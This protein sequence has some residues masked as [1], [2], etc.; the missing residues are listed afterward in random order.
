LNFVI[1][2]SK[3]LK[4]TPITPDK[5]KSYEIGAQGFNIDFVRPVPKFLPVM[6]HEL[7]SLHPSM[8][9]D[10]CWEYSMCFDNNTLTN[11][12]D[13]IV[14]ASKTELNPQEMKVPF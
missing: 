13:L 5:L 8:V 12:K 4:S 11:A 6:P 10:V 7:F 2:L 1:F 14:K 9:P 3:F